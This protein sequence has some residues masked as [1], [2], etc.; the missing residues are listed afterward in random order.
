MKTIIIAPSHVQAR[1]ACHTWDDL[2][3]AGLAWRPEQLQGILGRETNLVVI[4]SL[5]LGPE[6]ARELDVL[7]AS[8]GTVDYRSA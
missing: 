7:R 1:A 8:G 4:N 3:D 2:H 6:L 5:D